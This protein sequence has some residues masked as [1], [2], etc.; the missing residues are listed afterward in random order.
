MR[1]PPHHDISVS[2]H[3]ADEICVPKMSGN[4][5]LCSYSRQKRLWFQC[6]LALLKI[7]AFFSSDDFLIISSNINSWFKYFNF[8]SWFKFIINFYFSTD[9]SYII[10]IKSFYFIKWDRSTSINVRVLI[11]NFSLVFL[12][13]FKHS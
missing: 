8:M 5:L 13:L 11:N 6:W 12:F 9:I 10:I 1:S 4:R 3:S 2:P 7:P